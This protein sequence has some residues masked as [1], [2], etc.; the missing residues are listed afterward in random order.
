MNRGNIILLASMQQIQ[1][2]VNILH[3][4]S[5]VC[6]IIAVVLLIAAVVEFF[7][8]DIF[9]II[10]I[11]SG[12]AARM[13][14]REL[15]AE[16][17][18][19]GRLKR[20]G[21][22]AHNMWNTASPIKAQQGDLEENA[23]SQAADGGNA[24]APEKENCVKSTAVLEN[25]GADGTTLLEGLGSNETTLLG[26]QMQYDY[27]NTNITMPLPEEAPVKIGKFLIVRNIMMIHTDEVI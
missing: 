3:T 11:K 1:Q 4:I 19:S 15:E 26:Q 21:K 13:G 23:V 8:L 25:I 10:L 7:L 14:I 16:N 9:K 18:G 5:M 24:A 20:K 6:A 12:R 27:S 2:Q 17:A 22:N